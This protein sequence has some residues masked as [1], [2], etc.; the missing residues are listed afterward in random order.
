M[1]R[2][3]RRRPLHLTFNKES[4]R[5]WGMGRE[6]WRFWG[7]GICVAALSILTGCASVTHGTTQSVK[8]D[9]RT[10]GGEVI[11][12]VECRVSND[13]GGQSTALSGQ[14]V[15]VRRSGGNLSIDCAQAGLP[16]AKGTVV[17]HINAGIVGNVLLGGVVG[18]AID[19][20][21]GAGFSYPGWL[22]LVFGEI[23]RFE[24][25]GP[26]G[27]AAMSGTVQGTTTLADAAP[28]A[29]TKASS[30]EPKLGA[31]PASVDGPGIK[32]PLR[33]GDTLE[34]ELVDEMTGNRAP[35]LYRLDRIE[36]DQMVFNM[37]ARVEQANGR[38]V[39]IRTP[40]A[41]LFDSASPPGGWVSTGG[42]RAGTSW[43]E[44][45]PKHRF[46]ATV[47]GEE[48][49]KVGGEMLQVVRIDYDGWMATSPGTIALRN[50]PMAATAWYSPD[51][52]RVVRFDIQ[53]MNSTAPSKESLQLK[54]VL[55]Y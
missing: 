33:R 6:N 8:I 53:A 28:A 14:S 13:R 55:R 36:G 45:Y 24:G 7:L 54:R 44:E 41:G 47:V 51:L 30:G 50:V 34:Y 11:Q 43:N 19:A 52:K 17:S 48:S 1:P 10:Q 37:G 49:T 25:M 15:Q 22:Q 39:S 31:A 16:P 20:G 12:G 35:V 40:S 4:Q 42:L 27:N 2:L 5:Q 38:L 3:V 21:T 26:S 46:N 9:T 23:R 29:G 32:A 18:A